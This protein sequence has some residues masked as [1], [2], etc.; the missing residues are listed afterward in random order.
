VWFTKTTTA[1]QSHAA[2]ALDGAAVANPTDGACCIPELAANTRCVLLLLL[3][4]LHQLLV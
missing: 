2:I 1:Q 3:L 4:L